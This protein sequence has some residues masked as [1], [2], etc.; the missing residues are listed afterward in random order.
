MTAVEFGLLAVPFFSII[1]AI[2]ETS[3]VFLSG[4]ILDSAVQ[5]VSRL[6]R[7]GQAQQASMTPAQ[8]KQNVCD[9]LFGL[10]ADCDGL[11]V[12]VQVVNNFNAASM[13]PPVNWNCEAG[14]DGC[15]AWTRPEAFTP[16]Q[17]SS[18][19]TVQV[20]YRWPVILPLGGLG[21]GNLPDGNRLMGAATVFRNEPFT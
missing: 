14:E 4:Q 17:G 6:I 13:T 10:F 12:E 8:F 5:D 16:G 2:L 18:I 1:G 11:H 19:V 20:Y 21:M 3:V 9:R 7:T 15:D